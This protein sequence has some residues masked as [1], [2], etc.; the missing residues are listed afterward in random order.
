MLFFLIPF[1]SEKGPSVLIG[2]MGYAI[3]DL[4]QHWLPAIIVCTMWVSAGGAIIARAFQPDWIRH[5]KLLR[6]LFDTSILWILFRLAGAVLGTMTLF[7]SGPEWVWGSE[8]G[9]LVLFELVSVLFVFFFLAG[10][11]LP[12]LLDYGLVELI[13]SL[14]HWF[15]KPL[16]RIPGNSGVDIIASLLGDGTVGTLITAR[17]Y[18]SGYYT[19]REA[20]I[21]ASSFSIVSISF[22]VVVVNFA[23]LSHMFLAFY[24]TVI[25]TCLIVG[26]VLPRIWPLSHIPDTYCAMADPEVAGK[27]Q[28]QQQQN[29]L[30][31][32]LNKAGQGPG[33]RQLLRKGCENALDI[34]L[35]FVPIIMTIAT[36]GL[37]LGQTTD[38]FQWLG[39]PVAPILE[40][41][42]IPEAEKAAPAVLLGFAD[43]FLPVAVA[44]TIENEM[45]RFVVAALSIAQ[46]IY[47][48][49]VGVLIMRSSIPL[50]FWQLLVLF[51]I[52]T[53]L[54]LPL[55]T[56]FAH[57]IY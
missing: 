12:F 10:L 24:L 36:T 44:V 3:L 40:L 41:L 15:L 39:A 14:M 7:G 1:H 6:S 34:W 18:E 11:F 19:A 25:S 46:L 56:L 23:Q 38:L 33:V 9:G 45:A 50:N 47:M 26:L 53:V 37:I 51:L 16:Y 27:A 28:E 31:R 43:M 55:I 5:N 22:C 49:E 30:V 2:I 57:L 20:A 48:S 13:G 35:V 54:A 17:Q 8:T 21:I 29:G 4:I 32:A 52:R 42:G